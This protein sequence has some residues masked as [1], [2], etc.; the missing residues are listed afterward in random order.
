MIFGLILLFPGFN[1]FLGNPVATLGLIA[2]SLLLVALP[3]AFWALAEKKNSVLVRYFVAF[4]NLVLACLLLLRWW[5]SSHF[6]VSNLYES[7]CFL[8]WASTLAQLLLEK[9]FLSPIVPASA[10]PISLMII[11]FASF[12]LPEDLQASSS[13]VPA[14]RSSWLVMHVTVIMCSYASLIIGS[15]LSLSVLLTDNKTNLQ[16]R[17]SSTGVGGFR[18]LTSSNMDSFDSEL[19][20]L[21]PLVISKGEQLDSLSYRSIT[22]GFLLLTVGLISGAVWANEAWGTWWS[23][24]PKETWAFIT[25]LVYAAYLH[26]RLVK[27]W[28]GRRPAVLALFGFFV[29]LI[30]YLGVNL[31]GVGLHSYGWFLS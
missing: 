3:F 13:L 23:W 25:W 22:V 1:F 10:T 14:L 30:C 9:S 29:I 20:N 21:S 7:L 31:L 26:V 15:M 11:A 12:A 4:A 16:I 24:D 5:Q 17:S 28:Q 18:T 8:A 6:P 27:G 2:F 19:L